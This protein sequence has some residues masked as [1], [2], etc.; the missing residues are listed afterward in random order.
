MNYFEFVQENLQALKKEWKKFSK[1]SEGNDL[2]EF[3]LDI[4]QRQYPDWETEE[5]LNLIGRYYDL[6]NKWWE[7]LENLEAKGYEWWTTKMIYDP[8]VW[9]LEE[10]IGEGI[11][12]DPQSEK[13]K[14]LFIVSGYDLKDPEYGKRSAGSFKLDLRNACKT[15]ENLYFKRVDSPYVKNLGQ[16]LFGT[17]QWK[18][19]FKMT[20][21]E[22]GDE[23]LIEI[24]LDKNRTGLFENY[25]KDMT[26]LIEE[27]LKKLQEE[28][29][30]KGYTRPFIERIKEAVEKRAEIYQKDPIRRGKIAE[31]VDKN[32]PKSVKIKEINSPLNLNFLN[33]DEYAIVIFDLKN[34]AKMIPLIVKFDENN[35][36][37]SVIPFD[38]RAKQLLEELKKNY[39]DDIGLSR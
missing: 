24:Y 37:K 13:G 12:Q 31:Y 32:F 16:L 11:G 19:L 38:D 17:P 21:V 6:P 36:I 20:A 22:Q 8:F 3:F 25:I 27:G 30:I 7:N 5:N 9:Y 23:A 1:Q 39:Q 28:G 18:G 26:A 34:P 10:K 35:N 2:W 14:K 15:V 29:I 33:E 4:V